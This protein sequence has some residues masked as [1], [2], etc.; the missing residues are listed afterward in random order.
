MRVL[1]KLGFEFVRR[2]VVG[3]LDTVFY[4]RKAPEAS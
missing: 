3:G 4:Q 1:E 2:A